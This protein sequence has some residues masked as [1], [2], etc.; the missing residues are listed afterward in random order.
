VR[1]DRD[2]ELSLLQQPLITASHHLLNEHLQCCRTAARCWLVHDK[3]DMFR[4]TQTN[5]ISCAN[6]RAASLHH[7]SHSQCQWLIVLVFPF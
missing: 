1:S 2:I 5:V 6:L 3:P 4:S 7:T